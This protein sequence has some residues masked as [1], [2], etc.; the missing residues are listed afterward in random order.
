MAA[1]EESEEVQL[2]DAP[3]DY[4]FGLADNAPTAPADLLYMMIL[5]PCT[6]IQDYLVHGEWDTE[7]IQSDLE[8]TIE[9]AK[10]K[11]LDVEDGGVR[12]A[13][14]GDFDDCDEVLPNDGN[15][16]TF[17]FAWGQADAI[18]EG[19]Q[20]GEDAPSAVRVDHGEVEEL[21]L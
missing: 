11:G 5:D 16:E 9:D 15:F 1:E 19:A 13:L 12:A 21:E 20:L 17:D 14:D 2:P 8:I 3:E 7:A 18:P 6:E 4:R 10:R